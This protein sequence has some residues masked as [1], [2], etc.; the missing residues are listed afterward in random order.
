MNGYGDLDNVS[1]ALQ[2]FIERPNILSPHLEAYEW[3]DGHELL[4]ATHVHGTNLE[5]C[6]EGMSEVARARAV[7]DTLDYL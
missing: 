4:E 1:K 7:S 3:E 6:W 5:S 2:L